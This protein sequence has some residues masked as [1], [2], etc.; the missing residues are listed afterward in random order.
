[1]IGE[2]FRTLP[3]ALA[4]WWEFGDGFFGL[5]LMVASVALVV[6]FAAV[7]YRLRETQGWLSSLFGSMA[8][9]VG[10]WWTLGIIPS[11][12]IYFADSQRDLLSDSIIPSA[13]V[14]GDL[15]VASNFYNV[16]RDS[17]L[18]LEAGIVLGVGVWLIFAIQKRFPGGLAEGEDRG[19]TS[20]GYK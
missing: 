20:G 5:L 9:L 19:P 11:A 15:E 4:A 7:A 17:I 6:G 13:I 14:I 12:W 3:D 10:L 16:F 1:M 8:V 18:M 2:F